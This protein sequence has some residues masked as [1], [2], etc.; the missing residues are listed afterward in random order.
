MYTQIIMRAL[1]LPN[2]LIQEIYIPFKQIY[3]HKIKALKLV[4]LGVHKRVL[5]SVKKT[6]SED[7]F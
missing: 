6:L 1:I 2:R 3:K 4:K 7:I 5:S